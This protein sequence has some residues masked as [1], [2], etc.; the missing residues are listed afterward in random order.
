MRILYG[1]HGY[2]RGHATR[3][4]AVLPHLA[5]RHQVL[6]LAGGDAYQAISP[7]FP[8]VRIPTLGFAYNPGKGARERC[9][10][11]TLQRNLPGF[12]DV[13][14]G[15]PTFQMVRDIVEEHSPDVILSDA[16]T[17]THHV[18]AALRIP[19][20][21]F[22]HIGILA[23]C[24]PRI[25][26]RDRLEAEV[27]AWMYRRLMGRPQRIIVSSFYD[28][29]PRSPHVH[30]VGT[31]PRQAVRG[32]VPHNGDHL[33]AY[34]NKGNEQVTREILDTLNSVGCPVHLYGCSQ[35]GREG[36]ISFLP[37]STLPFLEDLAGCRA[38]ISTAGNQLMGEAIFLGKPVLVM[39]ERCV[40]QRLNAAAVERLGIG[41]R[42]N[43]RQLNP[44]RL[45]TFLDHCPEFAANTRL[46][47]RDGLPAA[48]AI[49]DRY[50]AELA[51]ARALETNP[52]ARVDVVQ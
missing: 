35:R 43:P 41:M 48:I 1:V 23:Y 28:A 9:D 4:L 5:A 2:G 40:E 24:R 26:W 37:P 30:V 46:H 12:L 52:V 11:R 33:L 7:D 25:E 29:P 31:L 13:K 42:L 10:W 18:A 51:P 39:P 20:I 15:G 49:I 6:V 34:L 14:F 17:W 27:D 47:I 22:D 3:T 45:R 32:L 50:L 38:V 19:R 16:E 36:N 8:V 44:R 21:S